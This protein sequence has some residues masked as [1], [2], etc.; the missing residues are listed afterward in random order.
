[1]CGVRRGPILLATAAVL[2]TAAYVGNRAIDDLNRVCTLIGCNSGLF[3]DTNDVAYA[4]AAASTLRVCVEQRCTDIPRSETG[5]IPMHPVEHGF[6]KPREV[7]VTAELLDPGG[8]VLHRSERRLELESHTPN[9]KACD[10]DGCTV[11]AL[12]IDRAGDLQPDGP[13][14]AAGF[15]VLHRGRVLAPGAT[16]RADWIGETLVVDAA[17]G[18]REVTATMRGRRVGAHRFGGPQRYMVNLPRARGRLVIRAGR[19]RA[20]FRVRSADR[21]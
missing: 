20:T 2:G 18:T 17:P 4:P 13:A 12:R 19:D 21:G 1:M 8:R 11:G 9:G 10:G 6:E 15:A 7:T 3:L 14:P 5:G 16:I